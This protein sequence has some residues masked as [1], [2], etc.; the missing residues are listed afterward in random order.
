MHARGDPSVSF[1]EVRSVIHASRYP[2]RRAARA[3]AA[4][5]LSLS[6]AA[7]PATAPAAPIAA[8]MVAQAGAAVD[9]K[10]VLG[11]DDYAKW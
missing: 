8:Q 6:A 11:I 4:L 2:T 9:G 5:G 7:I 1:S 10:K 3:F